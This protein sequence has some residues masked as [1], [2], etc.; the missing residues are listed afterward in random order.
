MTPPR[1]SKRLHQPGPTFAPDLTLE[2]AERLHLEHV[3]RLTE[4]DRKRACVVLGLSY[5]RLMNLISKH[6]L[7]RDYAR[8]AFITRLADSE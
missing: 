2:T 6:S 4:G 3:L 1:I 7:Y 5:T 8:D